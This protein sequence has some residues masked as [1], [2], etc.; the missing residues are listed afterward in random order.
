MLPGRQFWSLRPLRNAW[1]VQA[2]VLLLLATSGALAAAS[3]LPPP[4]LS[5]CSVSARFAG[6]NVRVD[7][8]G[9][10]S[11]RVRIAPT[12]LIDAPSP[13]ALTASPPPS[14]S[15]S[16][17]APL[18]DASTSSATVSPLSVTYGNLRVNVTE[19]GFVTVSRVSPP[20]V[21]LST[22]AL[23][24]TPYAWSSTFYK[25]T[26]PAYWSVNWTYS[27]PAGYTHGLGEHHHGREQLPYV[28]YSIP[29]TFAETAGL[30]GDVSI[31]WTLHSEGAA[32]LWNQPGWGSYTI[33][34]GTVVTWA[35][36]QAP[37]FDALVA[38]APANWTRAQ[39]RT[40]YE[41]LLQRLLTA[42]ASYPR[43]LP[44]YA[45]GFWQCK[46]RYRSQQETIDAA[47]GYVN[48]S[49]PLSVIVIDAGNW[50]QLGDFAFNPQCFPDPSAM[51]RQLRAHGIEVMV[52]LWPHAGALSA[53]FPY[54][55]SHDMLTH[56]ASGQFLN[57][58]IPWMP[59]PPG[60][61][62]EASAVDFIAPAAQA[63][64]S[65]LLQRNYVQ[66]GIKMFWLDADEPDCAYPGQQW[67]N[68]R[69]D[70]EIESVYPMG[71][72][73][74]VKMALEA[75]NVTDGMMLSRDTW[76]GGAPM[77]AAVWSGQ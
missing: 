74:T 63:Y 55:K 68:N 23:S 54:L 70:V 31:P 18:E 6:L 24:F 47:M 57:E 46:L 44:H 73:N 53:N 27:Q 10:D 49:L 2:A 51:V 36:V 50:A 72:I 42:T 30:K 21:L 43:P 41:P 60:P 1:L 16:A 40:P 67:W 64:V 61:Q 37:Q 12:P 15:A 13:Q 62:P 76:I 5:P 34:K 39:D 38:V 17:C 9:D 33:S 71:V 29:F 28:D 11:A 4:S 66:H 48:R 7:A 52:S 59:W 14:S 20:L 3:S 35:A 75:S 65:A 56:N 25:P 32:T 8:W 45:S 19:D 77:G 69:P 26:Y 58:S 22:T